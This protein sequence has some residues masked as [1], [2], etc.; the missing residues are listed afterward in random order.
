MTAIFGIRREDKNQWEQRTPIIP[1]HVKK[2]VDDNNISCI[3]QP[4]SIRAF[5][6]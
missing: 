3:V 6:D 2:L 1:D 4:S 5:T